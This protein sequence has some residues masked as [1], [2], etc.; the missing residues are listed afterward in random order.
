MSEQELEIFSGVVDWFNVERGYG[1]ITWEKGG[2][3]QTD[4]FCH[5]SDILVSGFKLLKEGQK[6]SFSIGVNNAGDPKATN[7]KVI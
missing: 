4:M 5:F 3:K 1:F 2:V 6:V 7:V